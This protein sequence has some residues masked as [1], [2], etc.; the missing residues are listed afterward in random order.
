M[1]GTD[2]FLTITQ[3]DV[4][5]SDK[6]VAILLPDWGQA[7]VNPKAINFLRKRLPEEGWTT[8]TI[9]PMEKPLGYPIHH[10]KPNI[11]EEE[12]N[13][14][15]IDY[16]Q[17]LS[18]MLTSVMEKAADYPGIFIVIAQGNNAAQLLNI[19]LQEEVEKP[20]ALI[21]LSA[22]L[23]TDKDNAQLSTSIAE[24]EIPILDLW[25]KKDSYWVNHFAKQRAMYARKELKTYYRQRQ[26][27]N[28]NT[29]YYPEQALAKEIKGWLTTI[30]W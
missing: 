5:S 18:P 3:P 28:F 20:N 7:A 11:A 13:K 23:L 25:L 4:H 15:L 24:S 26:L 14:L 30:G 12:N 6:G 1:I 16:Q 9:Q 2:D 10:E 8:I 27:T 19:Y 21:L 17:Q 29:G 22:H